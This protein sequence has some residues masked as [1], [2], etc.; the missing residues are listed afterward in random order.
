MCIRAYPEAQFVDKRPLQETTSY[1][2]QL[3]Y[4]WKYCGCE[5]PFGWTDKVEHQCRQ[6]Q[7][8]LGVEATHITNL[9]HELWAECR[10]NTKHPHH[11]RISYH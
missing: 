9:S 10:A 1:A 3:N 6:R 2:K 5:H 4:A 7:R 8:F 11:Y